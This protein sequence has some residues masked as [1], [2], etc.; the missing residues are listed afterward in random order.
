MRRIKWKLINEFRTEQ[1]VR[2]SESGV[3]IENF[4]AALN[5]VHTFAND[6][7]GRDE[8]WNEYDSDEY[9]SDENDS[10]ESEYENTSTDG[11]DELKRQPFY[12]HKQCGDRPNAHKYFF[13]DYTLKS[14]HLDNDIPHFEVTAI[15]VERKLRS[16]GILFDGYSRELIQMDVGK[17]SRLWFCTKST[18]DVDFVFRCLQGLFPFLTKISISRL[19]GLDSTWFRF[20]LPEVMST[21]PGCLE[22][23]NRLLMSAEG[24]RGIITCTFPWTKSID[25]IGAHEHPRMPKDHLLV[26]SFWVQTAYGTNNWETRPW[27]SNFLSDALVQP[28]TSRV[29][30]GHVCNIPVCEY[31]LKEGNSRQKTMYKYFTNV[32]VMSSDTSCRLPTK[33]Q[34]LSLEAVKYD[35]IHFI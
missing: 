7:F 33:E 11:Y 6:Y 19:F 25:S 4:K 28:L 3:K 5:Y 12:H 22:A 13:N 18:V 21:K 32:S 16:H 34:Q 1:I 14:I 31:R 8:S 10:D 23:A 29:Q 20:V 35:F 27:L 26:K 2:S 17:T 24:L 9:D 15:H 30:Q